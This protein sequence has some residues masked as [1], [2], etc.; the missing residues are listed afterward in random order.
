MQK[1][2]A[3]L[4]GINEYPSP[5][6]SLGG[7]LR[8]LDQIEGY[9][10]T[11]IANS[12]ITTSSIAGL[13]IK[14]YGDLQICRLE[15]EEA[16]Y[17]NIHKG[18][19]QF[20]QQATAKDVVWF[21]F[22][23]HG[24]EQP[25][26]PE[27]KV[28]EPNGKDQTLVC[29]QKT[30]EDYLH[31]ADKELAILL[32]QIATNSKEPPHILV[33][34]DCC[35]SGSGTRNII[36]D[37]SVKSRNLFADRTSGLSFSNQP[38]RALKTYANAF[39]S[40][41]LAQK[42]TVA[43][44]LAKHILFSACESIQL[45]GDSSTGGVF[46]SSLIHALS[47]TKGPINY[48]DLFIKTRAVIQKKHHNQSPQ[49]EPLGNFNPYTRFL[50]GTH[51]GTPNRFEIEEE[52]GKWW[53]KCGTIHGLSIQTHP[54]DLHEM[55]PNSPKIG[56]GRLVS[57]GGL[58]SEFQWTKGAPTT[59]AANYKA[60]IPTLITTPFLVGLTGTSTT[61]N[62][63]KANWTDTTS[64]NWAE[65][66]NYPTDC[67][68]QVTAN[69]TSYIIYNN[70]RN[71]EAL[72]WSQSEEGAAKFI[73]DA[74]HKMAKWERFLTLPKPR[75][76]PS[77][78]DSV[79]FELGIMDK[80]KEVTYSKASKIVLEASLQNCFAKEGAL[81]LGFLPRVQISSVRRKLY[82]YLFHLRTNYSIQSDEGAFIYRPEE[83]TGAI[84]LPLF[85]KTKAWGL[86]A[87]DTQ[88]KCW[89]KLIVTTEPFDH[90]Q[91]IQRDLFTKRSKRSRE[92]ITDARNEW[93]SWD[94]E[95]VMNRV[96]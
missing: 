73:V 69:E 19:T 62:L 21:H 31:L 78:A 22:S 20:L 85:K 2:Y 52:E 28:I 76:K 90:Y 53:V 38:S 7:C 10:K 71:K 65:G 35:H 42:G 58:E 16:T 40:Q 75:S 63:L 6:S 50:D 39:Y 60:I 17:H 61:L 37:S 46:T 92:I 48:V 88:V 94:I 27:F 32:Y 84:N 29:Y 30:Y 86:A 89:F 70:R 9:L 15:N 68:F 56:T 23:G 81:V 47:T 25:T 72:Q 83:H 74:L 14:Q 87:E 64:I 33:T 45:A 36:T 26:A 55:A 49:C 8:D 91:F 54:I 18:F 43:I 34:L 11:N 66:N 4:V 5:I 59:I 44:P 82:C 24:A 96:H 95:V 3:L 41:Q 51:L 13:P 12:T 57:I 77:I 93:F 80:D 67:I 79:Q 1:T